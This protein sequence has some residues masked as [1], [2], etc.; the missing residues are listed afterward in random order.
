MNY[1]A[2]INH[3]FNKLSLLNLKFEELQIDAGG[4]GGSC[5]V[6]SLEI[7]T[8]EGEYINAS[9]LLVDI[10]NIKLSAEKVCREFCFRSGH[11]FNGSGTDIRLTINIHRK[12]VKCMASHRGEITYIEKRKKVIDFPWIKLIKGLQGGDG[13]DVI[14]RFRMQS[15][16]CS[17]SGGFTRNEEFCLLSFARGMT[18]EAAWN[19]DFCDINLAITKKQIRAVSIIEK[20]SREVELCFNF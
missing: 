7:K 3:L 5:D 8:K 11:T 20:D 10:K 17:A 14:C 18:T 13:F 16:A 1:Q 2:C 19:E 9:N 12:T 6:F 15:I 4:G